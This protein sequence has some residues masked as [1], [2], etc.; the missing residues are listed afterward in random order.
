MKRF[1]RPAMT[2]DFE[3]FVGEWTSQQRRRR[4]IF[5]DCDQWYEFSGFTKC[6]SIFDGAGNIDEVRFPDQGFGG[7]TLR[8]YDAERDEWSLY[9]ASTRTPLA[10]PPQ[11]GRFVDGRGEFFADDVFNGEPIR[12]VFV[13][14]D[15]TDSSARWEQRFS[16]DGGATWESN[17][18]AD[19]TRTA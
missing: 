13:W 16:R 14:S 18:I 15:I 19:F 11:V 12:V 9:W 10:L 3:F 8:L 4:E 2:T 5:A 1:Y 17:W 7:V 6:W